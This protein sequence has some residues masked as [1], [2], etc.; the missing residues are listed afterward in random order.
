MQHVYIPRI[1]DDS[2][3]ILSFTNQEMLRLR[4]LSN[5]DFGAF[6]DLEVWNRLLAEQV[7]FGERTRD[8]HLLYLLQLAT[9][10]LILPIKRDFMKMYVNLNK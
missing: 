4:E 6:L 5:I 10:D 9:S 8:Q 7:F 3:T 1:N 2:Y